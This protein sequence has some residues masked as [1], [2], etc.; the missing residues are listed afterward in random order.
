MGT[1]RHAE[2]L[3][4][5][6]YAVAMELQFD[7]LTKTFG[8]VTAF[9][10]PTLAIESG[11]FFTFAGP[12]QS[13]KSTLLQVIAGLEAPST[14]TV[15]AGGRVLNDVQS[16]DRGVV[17]VPPGAG[18]DPG[19]EPFALFDDPMAQIDGAQRASAI[20]ALKRLHTQR[21]T[22]FIYA[23]SDQ[24]EALALSDRVA[25]LRDGVVQQVGTPADL[26]DRP[27]NIFVAGFFG[28]PPMN[29]VP[30]ILEK[31]GVAVEIGPRALQ[32]NGTVTEEYARDVFL[33]VRPEHV[34][35]RREPA[36]G[37]RGTATRVE[38]SAGG[39][40]IEV[41]VDGGEFVARED[42]DSTY[43]V[44]DRVLVALAARHLHVFD[45]PGDRL[46]V[47]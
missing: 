1:R 17:L 28:N 38:P 36:T 44:G 46:K 15:S 9:D 47:R 19:S 6:C 27:A 25:L 41:R 7:H 37:W 21:G 33:G 12:P 24:G 40:V 30:G 29:V 34:R 8:D 43:H 20:E 32:L 10:I 4:P 26:F 13:G 2:V 3:V 18:L 11:E 22:T 39:T 42:G 45:A 35:L 5:G 23:T 14:G 16:G 31:D